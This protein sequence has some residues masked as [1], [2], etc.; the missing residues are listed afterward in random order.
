ME[1]N[2]VVR[3]RHRARRVGSLRLT[4]SGRYVHHL[5]HIGLTSHGLGQAAGTNYVHIVA[6]F[7]PEASDHALDQPD[8]AK[9]QA[10]LQGVNSVAADGPRQ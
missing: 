8:V 10:A 6:Q 3:L 4:D 1:W 5:D 9:D 7:V 2:G